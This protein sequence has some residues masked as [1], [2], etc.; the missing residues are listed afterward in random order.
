MGK[1]KEQRIKK[2]KRNMRSLCTKGDEKLARICYRERKVARRR[3]FKGQVQQT[4]KKST[5][6]K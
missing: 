5:A 6:E 3:I 4:I 2:N 1:G